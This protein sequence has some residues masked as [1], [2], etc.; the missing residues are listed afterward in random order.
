MPVGVYKRS[1]ETRRKL[2]EA[3]KGVPRS[4]AKRFPLD[5]VVITPDPNGKVLLQPVLIGF[6]NPAIIICGYGTSFTK[7]QFMAEA[8]RVY[9]HALKLHG[10]VLE[11]GGYK[12]IHPRKRLS[13]DIR[14]AVFQR[15]GKICKHCG[16][17]SELTID[18]KEPITMGGT[19]DLSNL[20]VLC[21]S[22]NS[23]KSNKVMI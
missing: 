20:Q 10:F 1:E 7:E 2:S 8:E 16:A 21:R 15:D 23:K 22:C 13:D 6:S 11:R 3:R 19:N 9:P 4:A 12:H 18:H 17:T 5:K 14:Q